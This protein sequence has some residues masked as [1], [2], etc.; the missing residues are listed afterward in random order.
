MEGS[1]KI[2]VIDDDQEFLD[3]CKRTFN[4]NLCQMQF[5][6]NRVQAQ[7]I[8][9]GSFNLIIVGCLP[10]AGESFR[11]QQWIKRHPIYKHIPVLVIDACFD[12]R[13]W[14]GWRFFE[15]LEIDAEEYV[16]KP[17]E[18]IELLPLIERLCMNIVNDKRQIVETLWQAFLSLDNVDRD[19]FA[20]RILQLRA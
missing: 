6:S 19:I 3:G 11:L 17:L 4:G 9:N 2:L 15:G 7:Q 20:N 16:S 8:I 18:P 5:A 13:R 10:P 14:K 1:K 12:E